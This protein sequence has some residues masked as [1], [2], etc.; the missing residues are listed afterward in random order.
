MLYAV[1]E[2]RTYQVGE[3]ETLRKAYLAQGFDIVDEN[4]KVV[5]NSPSKTVPYSQYAALLEENTKLKEQIA[6]SKKTK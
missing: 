5:E 6:A 1:K 2:N 3:N 4:G